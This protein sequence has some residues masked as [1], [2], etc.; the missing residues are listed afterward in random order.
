MLAQKQMTDYRG[1]FAPGAMLYFALHEHGNSNRNAEAFIDYIAEQAYTIT[2]SGRRLVRSSFG[3]R[4][5]FSSALPVP[6][7]HVVPP[8][9]EDS[10]SPAQK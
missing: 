9:T 6:K 8:G 3:E 5:V 1:H 4:K 10:L 7:T 2:L